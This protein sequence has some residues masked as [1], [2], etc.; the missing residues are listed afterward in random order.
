MLHMSWSFGG[1]PCELTST[2]PPESLLQLFLLQYHLSLWIPGMGVPLSGIKVV[3]RTWTTHQEDLVMEQLQDLCNRQEG[4]SWRQIS[5]MLSWWYH[6]ATQKP[7][8][9]Q[10]SVWKNPDLEDSWVKKNIL[11][12]L[13][14]LWL[15]QIGPGFQAWHHGTTPFFFFL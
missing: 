5:Q 11:A 15:P 2:L 7:C 8:R 6:Q 3:A 10:L 12:F 1:V 9:I 4:V 14:Y 13:K